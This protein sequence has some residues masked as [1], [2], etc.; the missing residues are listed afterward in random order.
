MILLEG[1]SISRSIR[2][3]G[4]ETMVPRLEP[5]NLRLAKRRLSGTKKGRTR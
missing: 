2:D 1:S 3:D 5:A 4:L